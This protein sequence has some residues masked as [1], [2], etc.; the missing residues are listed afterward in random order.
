MAGENGN[1]REPIPERVSIIRRFPKEILE[2]LTKEDL[3]AILY[4]EKLSA[5]LGEKL[6]DYLVEE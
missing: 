2:S 6:K 4:D 5:S 1:K 3:N